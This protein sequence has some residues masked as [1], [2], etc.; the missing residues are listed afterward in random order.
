MAIKTAVRES[1]ANMIRI[2]RAVEICLVAGE[3][4]GGGSGVCC[5]MTAVA[6]C[7]C[8]AIGQ[9]KCR[10]MDVS[11]KLPSWRCLAMTRFA[12]LRES[13]HRMIG[14]CR[15]RII[16]TMASGALRRRPGKLARQLIRVASATVGNRMRTDKRKSTLR[17]RFKLITV[18]DPVLRRMTSLALCPE[19]S[20]VD[21]RM[22][23]RAC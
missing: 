9:W 12:I 18:A 2:D 8:V 17:V 21:I 7:A 11:R 10:G 4:I 15:G 13:R 6:S 23:I 3:A 16:F 14:L 19:L 22:T 5:R 1:G 20:P